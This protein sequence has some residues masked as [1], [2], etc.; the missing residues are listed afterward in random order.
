MLGKLEKTGDLAA[1]C[2]KTTTTKK[3]PS[4]APFKP[5]SDFLLLRKKCRC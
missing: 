1:T 4:F 2:K 3:Q 5:L